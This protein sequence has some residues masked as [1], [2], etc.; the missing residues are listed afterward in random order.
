[1]FVRNFR[2][3]SGTDVLKDDVLDAFK[4]HARADAVI[5]SSSG[6]IPAE[7][8]DGKNPPHRM[9][10]NRYQEIVEADHFVCTMEWPSKEDPSPVVFG[11]ELPAR[12]S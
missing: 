9:A 12:E 11:V 3:G 5:V 6:P 10:A 8:V 7:N 2:G 1:M 4:R